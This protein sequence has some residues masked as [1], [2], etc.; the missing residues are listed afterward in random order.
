MDNKKQQ[1]EFIDVRGTLLLWWSK[2]YW[3]AISAFVCLALA[4]I[5]VTVKKPVY[6]VK[7]NIVISQEDSNIMSGMG[8]FG[9]LFGTSGYVDD[10]VFIVSS[11]TVLRDVVKDLKLHRCCI[12][13]DGILKKT[14]KFTKYPVEVTTD[15]DLADTLSVSLKFDLYVDEDGIAEV[16]VKDS[17][18]DVV[19]DVENQ[20]FPIVLDTKYGVFTI[21]KTPDYKEGES[22]KAKLLYSGYDDAAE[23]LKEGLD[24]YIASKKSNVIQIE[25]ETTDVEKA[26]QILNDIVRYYN[27]RGVEQRSEQSRL[28]LDFLDSRIQLISQ[29]LTDSE[30]DVEGYKKNQGIVD[31]STEAAYQTTKRGKFESELVQA[32]TDLNIMQMTKEFLA[33]SNNKYEL[34]PTTVSEEAVKTGITNYNEL[35]LARMNLSRTAKEGNIAL[36]RMN[37]RIDAL[38]A[39]INVSLDRAIAQQKSVIGDMKRQLGVTDSRLG[40][41]PTQER[42]YRDIKRKQS[43]KEQLYLF[44]MQRRED[45]ALMIANTTPKGIIVDKAFSLSEPISMK[46]K[47]VLLLAFIFSLVIPPVVLAIKKVLRNKFDT[48]DE[49][50]SLT[51]IPVIGEICKDSSGDNIVVRPGSVSTV[52][53]LFRAVR[54]NLQQFFLSGENEKVVLMTSTVSGE[55]KSFVSVNLAQTL[56]ITNDNLKVLLVGMDIRKPRIAEYLSIPASRGLTD[57]VAK[58]GLNIDEIIQ[59]NPNGL[60]FDVITSGPIPPNPAELLLN[61]RIDEMFAELRKRYDYI[62]VDTAPVGLVSDTLTLSRIGDATIYVCRAN[63]TTKADIQY[64]NGVYEEGRLKKMSILLNDTIV[65]KGYGYGYGE[66]HYSK[67]KK[68]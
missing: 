51:D 5:Y 36:T 25:M 39:N 50:K 4:A 35:V 37:E 16:E 60:A 33:D 17:N 29:D 19:A 24:I 20:K 18:K 7:S 47:M 32:E 22:L 34:I 53:E 9:E 55:G 28:T 66:N 1:T 41:I 46:K 57:Y 27:I 58:D 31:V 59:K 49:L 61:Q 38:R 12:V 3:F 48:K 40:N 65:S 13:K 10:E 64:A 15:V 30:A 52:A 56:A 26:K 6:L 44:L 11:H 21:R 42:Q 14:E 8:G 62:V 68:K 2:W 45:T 63:Y 67:K 23:S 54:S 43:I